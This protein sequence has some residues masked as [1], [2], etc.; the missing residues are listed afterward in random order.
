MDL[1][2]HTLE[3]TLVD[4]RSLQDRVYEQLK[5]WLMAGRF[6]PGEM[7]TVRRLSGL[8]GT[9]PMPVRDALARLVAERA[10]EAL[11]NRTTWVP[12]LSLAHFDELWRLRAE[13]EGRA[14]ALAARRMSDGEHEALCRQQQEIDAAIAAGDRS[15]Y[16]ILNY[17]FHFTVYSAASTHVLFRII[18]SLWMQYGSSLSSLIRN[19]DLDFENAADLHRHHPVIIASL[20][21]RHPAEA[22]RALAAD[23]RDSALIL[24]RLLRGDGAG[25]LPEAGHPGARAR[26]EPRQPV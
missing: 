21:T 15:R 11:P 12:V 18:E 17:R 24:R 7:I 4:R 19:P 1:S 16:L 9:S 2:D 5:L 3:T 26:A 25:A 22:R 10:L 13:L 14:A 6:T 23:I 20:R 8:L